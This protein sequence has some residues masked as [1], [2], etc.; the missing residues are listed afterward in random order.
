MECVIADGVFPCNTLGGQK[1]LG[2]M[3][4]TTAEVR[5]PTCVDIDSS[6]NSVSDEAGN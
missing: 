3:L 4:D 1:C 6:N 5:A 2:R